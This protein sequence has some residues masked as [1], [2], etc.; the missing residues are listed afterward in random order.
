MQSG[1]TV[2]CNDRDM[3]W[4]HVLHSN[5]IGSVAHVIGTFWARKVFA[6]HLLSSGG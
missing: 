1:H 4:R 6:S 2:V 3:F 5:G